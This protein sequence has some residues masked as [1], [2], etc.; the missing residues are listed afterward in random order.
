[1]AGTAVLVVVSSAAVVDD[2]TTAGSPISADT[3][4]ADPSSSAEQPTPPTRTA[5]AT[6]VEVSSPDGRRGRPKVAPGSARM[7]EDEGSA[8]MVTGR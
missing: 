8:V 7:E 4:G 2:S 1:V 6:A 5:S 3:A